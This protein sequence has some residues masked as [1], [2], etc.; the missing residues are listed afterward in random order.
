[1]SKDKVVI[2]GLGV[3]SPIGLDIDSFWTACLNNKSNVE[4][5]PEKW[6]DYSDYRSGIW[7]PLPEIDFKQYGFNR[8]DLM[9]RDPVSLIALMAAAQ[10][11]EQA[12]IEV[13]PTNDKNKQNILVG[14]DSNNAGVFIGTGIAGAK[15][16]FENNSCH[17]LKRTAKYMADDGVNPDLI[18]RLQHPPKTNPFA[19]SMLMQNSVS[20]TVGIKYSIHGRNRTI[21]QACSSGTTA[22]GSAYKAIKSGEI[23][24]AICGGSEFVYDDYGSLYMGFDIARA[25]VE[26]GNNIGKANRPFD[27]DRSGFLY[28]QG[29][30]GI[31]I[32]ETESRA[33]KRGATVLA[34]VA[35]YAE[36]FDAHSIMNINPEGKEI[37]RM[38]HQVVDDAKLQL[39]DIDY[40]NTHGTGT[41]L[42]DEIESMVIDDLFGNKPLVNSS[43]SLLGHTF[44]ASGALE[45]IISVLSLLNQTTHQCRNL[46]NPIRDLNFVTD[47]KEQN[48]QHVLTESFAF[49][50][51]NSSLILSIN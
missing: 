3:V 18:A 45:A 35:G 43:K 29:G 23:D 13:S 2:T 8:L 20:A 41:R 38:I 37:K 26:P 19:V 30:A 50:G 17:M 31:L 28:S 40:I 7:S 44:G 27:K 10:A 32:L 34:E 4:K 36:T 51:H 12:N 24:F 9:Q 33:K 1:M 15:T 11:L 39:S 6:N 16:L 22:I 5:I 42:N 49:G 14:V 46:D 48:I 21:S 47:I 25:L